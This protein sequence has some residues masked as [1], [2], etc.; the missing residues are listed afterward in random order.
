MRLHTYLIFVCL[1]EV[2]GCQV[3]DPLCSGLALYCGWVCRSRMQNACRDLGNVPRFSGAGRWFRPC[4]RCRRRDFSSYMP[5]V[6]SARSFAPLTCLAPYSP[7]FSPP[8]IDFGNFSFL[9]TEGAN[10][11]IALERDPAQISN[12]LGGAIK[13]PPSILGKSPLSLFHV[14]DFCSFRSLLVV[15]YSSAIMIENF[16][17]IG[18]AAVRKHSCWEAC[19]LS[20]AFV[21]TSMMCVSIPRTA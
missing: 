6:C 10:G 19:L 21:S 3:A 9:P 14:V 20:V 2:S 13:V 4:R 18:G 1:G 5:Q 16:A 11:N 15:S 7:F 8:N 12:Q 17:P